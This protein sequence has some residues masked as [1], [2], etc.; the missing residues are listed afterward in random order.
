MAHKLYCPPGLDAIYLTLYRRFNRHKVR[1]ADTLTGTRFIPFWIHIWLIYFLKCHE[2][3]LVCFIARP[4]SLLTSEGS[5]GEPF[6]DTH[7]YF[8]HHSKRQDGNKIPTWLTRF[9]KCHQ[10]GQWNCPIGMLYNVLWSLATS[11]QSCENRRFYAFRI[12]DGRHRGFIGSH[13]KRRLSTERKW[14]LIV[15][16]RQSNHL[17]AHR[18]LCF[19]ALSNMCTIVGFWVVILFS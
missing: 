12:C 4:W 15:W 19:D 7:K 9:S 3:Q 1:Y 8:L 2:R 10:A 16:N 14:D 5:S 18:L 13:K 17:R 6:A 11:D